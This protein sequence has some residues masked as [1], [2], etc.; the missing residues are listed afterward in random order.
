MGKG[1]LDCQIRFSK[2]KLSFLKIHLSAKPKH[3][4][5]MVADQ[6]CLFPFSHFF[7]CVVF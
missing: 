4:S 1:M 5:W 7:K 2:T 6:P 3:Q